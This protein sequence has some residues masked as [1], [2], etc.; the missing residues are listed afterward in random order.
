MINGNGSISL[1]KKATENQEIPAVGFVKTTFAHKASAGAT[2][3]NL[4]AL[5]IPT[6]M[7][8]NGFA[9]PTASQLQAANLLFFR[10]N[11]RLISSARGVLVDTLSYTL[12]GSTQINFIGF[13]ALEGEI[14]VG[15]V[16]Y[17]AQT[18][19]KVVDATATPATGVLTAG[20]TDFNIGQSF[21]TNKYATRQIGAA[22]I[23]KD[24]VLQVRNSN[25]SSV[26]LDGNYYEVDNGGGSFT[27]IRFNVADTYDTN[28][29]AIPTGLLSERPDGS[30]MAVIESVQGQVNSM[31]AYV[32]SLAGQTTTT[33]LGSSP[34][35]VD[36]KTFGDRVLSLENNRARIDVSNAWTANQQLLGLVTG[37]SIASGYIGE[38]PTQTTGS[39]ALTTGTFSNTNCASI[40]L[41]AGVWLVI[42]QAAWLYLPSNNT[43]STNNLYA[44]VSAG[45]V[46]GTVSNTFSLTNSYG[47]ISTLVPSN[48]LAN[49]NQH[50]QAPGQPM[51]PMIFSKSSSFTVYANA[52][53]T[54][55]LTNAQQRIDM[56]LTAIRIG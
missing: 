18:G 48:T 24:G 52:T 16:D 10:N 14:F 47:R 33:I 32:A 6:E 21:Q 46:S 49:G 29:V 3:I 28:I 55:T 15:T 37:A 19:L 54:V 31:A 12:A 22:Q 40:N 13:T 11:L 2:G 44:E 45:L 8:S 20:T 7:S 36:L 39:S 9:N 25:N 56:W 50:W 53:S 41:S 38:A 17:G 1:R 5:T 30:M 4:S 23:W 43:N 42:P 34:T 35:N 51:P 27:L 26:T